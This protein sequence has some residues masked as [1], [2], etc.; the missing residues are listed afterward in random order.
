[1]YLMYINKAIL[2]NIYNIL[3]YYYD[4]IIYNTIKYH[5][6]IRYLICNIFVV[7]IQTKNIVQYDLVHWKIT[8]NISYNKIE[9]MI[10]FRP[11]IAYLNLYLYIQTYV[12]IIYIYTWF[13]FICTVWE[14][15][16]NENEIHIINKT[17][18]I[19][20]YYA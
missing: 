12:F 11:F 4:T 13:I 17:C 5:F 9:I 16:K 18:N 15:L 6:I 19:T 1:M 2:H 14:C 3:Y 8:N 10:F 7:I 20:I